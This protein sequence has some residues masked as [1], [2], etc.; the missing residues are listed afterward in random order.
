MFLL[1]GT[2]AATPHQ[3]ASPASVPPP[4]RFAV[5]GLWQHRPLCRCWADRTASIAVPIEAAF[6][7]KSFF[8]SR[9]RLEAPKALARRHFVTVMSSGGSPK[10]SGI[11]LLMYHAIQKGESKRGE[12]EKVQVPREEIVH[13]RPPQSLH[14][15]SPSSCGSMQRQWWLSGS[16]S[17]VSTMRAA[18]GSSHTR[19]VCAMSVRSCRM[20]V[21]RPSR[22]RWRRRC[23]GLCS[24]S[25]LDHVRCYFGAAKRGG[26]AS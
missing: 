3:R 14:C 20:R 2:I 7:L 6:L 26:G 12:D 15:P 16:S 21:I 13:V 1:C 22:V 18:F 5:R 9:G 24:F 8:S 23:R 11:S 19:R 17:Q 10:V 4:P 25:S